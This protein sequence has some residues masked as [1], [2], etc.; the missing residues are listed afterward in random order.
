MTL[1]A[2][3]KGAEFASYA[4]FMKSL[5]SFQIMTNS[6]F[7]IE[8][9]KR[10]E[11]VNKHIKREENVYNLNFK[12]RYA[13]YI[14]K[15]HS[16]FKYHQTSTPD[17]EPVKLCP[18]FVKVS[19]YKNRNCLVVLDSYLLH[20]HGSDV[21]YRTPQ[22]KRRAE[23]IR[24]RKPNANSLT[25]CKKALVA[26]DVEQPGKEICFTQQYDELSKSYPEI[27]QLA[28][29]SHES[30]ETHLIKEEEDRN[31]EYPT[32]HYNS[33][34]MYDSISIPQMSNHLEDSLLRRLDMLVQSQSK[35]QKEIVDALKTEFT[36]LRMLMVKQHKENISLLNDFITVF[37]KNGCV[38]SSNNS[39]E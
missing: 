33:T 31:L 17:V 38:K 3:K 9:S 15:Q 29:E 39:G 35:F 19:A 23:I 18:V 36:A 4:D 7:V 37:G 28:N 22:L 2:L 26:T 24:K 13:K 20:N 10:I 14:C 1:D 5:N 25:D 27:H 12:Y 30:N 34:G 21:I 8:T 16:S 32:E 11:T 6:V